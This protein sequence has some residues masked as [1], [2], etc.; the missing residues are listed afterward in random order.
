[1]LNKLLTLGL[2]LVASLLLI[3][4]EPAVHKPQDSPVASLGGDRGSSNGKSVQVTMGGSGSAPGQTPSPLP[5][6]PCDTTNVLATWDVHS[7]V[8][9]FAD[10]LEAFIYKRSPA[11]RAIVDRCGVEW[12]DL[13]DDTVIVP[14]AITEKVKAIDDSLAITPPPTPAPETEP[15]DGDGGDGNDNGDET[16]EPAETPARAPSFSCDR[17]FMPVAV[18]QGEIDFTAIPNCTVDQGHPEATIDAAGY[19]SGRGYIDLPNHYSG[20]WT[21]PVTTEYCDPESW[22]HR[23]PSEP[24]LHHVRAKN[25]TGSAYLRI[26]FTCPGVVAPDNWVWGGNT[27]ESE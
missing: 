12:Y 26:A 23:I 7:F 1:M 22:K 25:S 3:G 21:A 18:K 2:V 15:E 13:D 9:Y 14:D 24:M 19:G 27:W 4:C 17:V 6:Q 8:A 10:G 11:P 16:E 20:D 5:H